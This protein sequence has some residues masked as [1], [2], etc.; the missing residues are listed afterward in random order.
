MSLEK[1]AK[2]KRKKRIDVPVHR[3]HQIDGNESERKVYS[4]QFNGKRKMRHKNEFN[5]NGNENFA[6]TEENLGYQEHLKRKILHLK[7]KLSNLKAFNEEILEENTLIKS[8]YKDLLKL[9]E[10]CQE[11]LNQ[12]RD[13]GNCEILKCSLE[14]SIDDYHTLKASNQQLIQDINMLKNVVYRLNVYMEGYQE[15]LRKHNLS[16]K[17]I[18][19]SDF[20]D[21]S[22]SLELFT[23]EAINSLSKDHLDHG[24]T[25]ISWGS[26]NSHTLGPLL[27]AYQETLDEK[28]EIIQNY[29]IELSHF[30]GRLQEIVNENEKLHKRLTEDDECSAKLSVEL[31]KIN[32]DLKNTKNE[33]DLLIKKCALKQTQLEEVLQCY[34]QKVEQLRRDYNVVVEQYHK[35]RTEISALKERNKALTDTQDEFK[36]QKQNYISLSMHNSSV[37]ECKKWYEELK[38]QYEQE[39]I[40]LKEN[41]SLLQ[42]QIVDLN[43]N[44]AVLKIGKEEFENKFKTAEKN[45]KKLETKNSVLQSSFQDMQLSRNACRK[46]LHKAMTFAKELVTEQEKLLH[47]LHLRQQENKVVKQMGSDI[48]NRMDSLKSQLKTVQREA[49]QELSTVEKRI[50]NQDSIINELKKEHSE[51]VDRLK[52]IIRKKEQKNVLLKNT[53]ASTPLSQCTLFKDKNVV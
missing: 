46:Q 21:A 40:K 51:E 14:K 53:D 9:Y 11:E 47:S 20:I 17:N 48:A 12:T 36:I 10:Y 37:N 31:D 8:Q 41:L 45:L 52:E 38:N 30:T 39:K 32:S 6:H 50:Y 29:E 25:P 49:W 42:N 16:I 4:A 18:N 24:H 34:E 43:K 33:N 23:T 3:V 44:I 26:V 1:S 5:E 22:N 13:C 7:E 2:T 35:S 28:E 19:K 27:D 15:K